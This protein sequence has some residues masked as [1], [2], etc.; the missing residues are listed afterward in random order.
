MDP[1]E[2]IV[3][4]WLERHMSS[5]STQ[6]GPGAICKGGVL[7]GPTCWI[8]EIAVCH[9]PCGGRNPSF[10]FRGCMPLVGY[11]CPMTAYRGTQGLSVGAVSSE[12]PCARAVIPLGLDARSQGCAM[13]QLREAPS[14][15]LPEQWA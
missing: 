13:R 4:P 12:G 15:R 3:H 11:T 6:R 2:G 10:C 5:G 7:G 1:G 14:G 9:Q 8:R